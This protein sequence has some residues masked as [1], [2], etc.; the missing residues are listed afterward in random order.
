MWGRALDILEIGLILTIV[1]LAVWV[2]G[3]YH[4]IRT[5]RG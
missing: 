1:P 5:V 2:S 4:W 3:L